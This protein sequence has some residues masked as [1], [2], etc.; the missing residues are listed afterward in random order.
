ML[1]AAAF[2]ALRLWPGAR[3]PQG[4][5]ARQCSKLSTTVRQ[6]VSGIMQ[7]NNTHLAPGFTLND[8]APPPAN[9]L[10]PGG[11]RWLQ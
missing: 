3:L 6:F 11:T 9:V 8:L 1:D 4:K 7:N 10:G 2:G 5:F